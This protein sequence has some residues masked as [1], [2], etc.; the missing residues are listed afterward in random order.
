MQIA[1]T[2]IFSHRW[3]AESTTVD[4]E[5]GQIMT[6]CTVDKPV[7]ALARSMYRLEIMAKPVDWSPQLKK[8]ELLVHEEKKLYN[9]MGAEFTYLTSDKCAQEAYSSN[10]LAAFAGVVADGQ[11]QPMDSLSLLKS[12]MILS[13]RSEDNEVSDLIYDKQRKKFV[14]N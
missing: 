6:F 7:M 1:M 9:S 12:K 4:E 13:S 10:I 2:L 5:V 11:E 8:T 14:S 3:L